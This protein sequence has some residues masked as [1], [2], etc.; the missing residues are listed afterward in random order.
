[1]E[2]E[3]F[4]TFVRQ[5]RE[6]NRQ[7]AEQ[8]RLQWEQKV[9]GMKEEDWSDHEKQDQVTKKPKS[10][11]VTLDHYKQKSKYGSLFWKVRVCMFYVLNSCVQYQV[12]AAWLFI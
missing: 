1:L 3:E 8:W 11:P 5:Q 2:E 6:T 10:K 4:E 9:N 12:S 7:K